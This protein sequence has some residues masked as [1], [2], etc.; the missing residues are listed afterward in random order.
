MFGADEEDLA[1]VPYCYGDVSQVLANLFSEINF[2]KVPNMENI[3]RCALG[4]D[5]ELKG[6]SGDFAQ[7]QEF[8][9]FQIEN[10][11][12]QPQEFRNSQ[13]YITADQFDAPIMVVVHDYEDG[14]DDFYE[15][16]QQ[17]RQAYMDQLESENWHKMFYQHAN[18][19]DL[20][21]VTRQRLK[22][23]ERPFLMILDEFQNAKPFIY[24]VPS[25]EFSDPDTLKA[26]TCPYEK[27]GF[28]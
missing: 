19:K 6:M 14:D 28:S 13:S 18:F 11:N 25:T 3:V 24:L 22:A 12:S 21:L 1:E 4:L 23:K 7:I 5:S 2:F 20:D 26:Y 15:L 8:I 27:L 16:K 10:V 17:I 9:Q